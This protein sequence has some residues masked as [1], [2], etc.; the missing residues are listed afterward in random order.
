VKFVVPAVVGV[1]E[2]CPFETLRVSPTGRVPTETDQVNGRVPPAEVNVWLYAA[3]AVPS[4]K[5]VVVTLGKGLTV[6]PR[7]LVFVAPLS[8][9]TWTVKLLVPA[10]VG[11]PEITPVAG[12]RLSPAG[13]LPTVIAHAY[14]VLP[15][16]AASVWLYAVFAVACAKLLVVTLNPA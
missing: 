16:A 3:P 14:G 4:V 8:S 13:R 7:A 11:V 12:L 15:P 1:P 9:V 6:M 10:V 2:I 5:A